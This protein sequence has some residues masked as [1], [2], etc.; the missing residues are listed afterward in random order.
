M[1][2]PS[3]TFFFFANVDATKTNIS[4]SECCISVI[5]RYNSWLKSLY[6]IYYLDISSFSSLA[7]PMVLQ[8]KTSLL[9]K[10]KKHS[11]HHKNVD[12]SLKNHHTLSII[13]VINFWSREFT[14]TRELQVQKWSPISSLLYNKSAA[15]VR[16][17]ERGS[18]RQKVFIKKDWHFPPYVRPFTISVHE[19]PSWHS[20]ILRNGVHVVQLTLH[21]CDD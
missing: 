1:L 2:L 18:Q 21:C 7:P 13:S 15:W 8:L 4:C 10:R 6:Q 14:S 9:F 19:Q 5:S 3:K 17:H 20:Y 12:R 16:T 11:E